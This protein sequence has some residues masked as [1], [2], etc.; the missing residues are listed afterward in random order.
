[1]SKIKTVYFNYTAIVW[2]GV[3]QNAIVD[4]SLLLFLFG[5]LAINFNRMYM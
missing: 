5:W 3:K 2:Q 1:M 4:E